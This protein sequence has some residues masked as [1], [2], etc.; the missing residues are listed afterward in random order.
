MTGINTQLGPIPQRFVIPAGGGSSQVRQPIQYRNE[1]L[2]SGA[3]PNGGFLRTRRPVL[4]T[5][6]PYASP[7]SLGED[8][9]PV[10]EESE[11]H[12]GQ[13]FV[14]QQQIHQLPQV[15][16]LQQ[17]TIRPSLPAVLYT[18]DE[19]GQVLDQQ[20]PILDFQS[21][22]RF[23]QQPIPD[24][25][26][27]TLRPTGGVSRFTLNHDRPVQGALQGTPKPQVS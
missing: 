22:P 26:P 6:I 25:V 12:E 8:A 1:R 21:S 23:I 15:H 7:N 5:P 20:R 13:T 9:K 18:T 17:Q 4:A 2:V 11:S 14:P 19:N 27:T 10:T 3:G 16:T 24:I